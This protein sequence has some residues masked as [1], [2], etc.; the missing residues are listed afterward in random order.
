MAGIDLDDANDE[1]LLDPAIYSEPSAANIP[2]DS[3]VPA[4]E[5]P[6]NNVTVSSSGP[7]TSNKP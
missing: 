6:P 5:E 1:I 7:T 2:G 4:V 3:K